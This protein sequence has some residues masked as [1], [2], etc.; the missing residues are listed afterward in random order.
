MS[1]DVQP[2][3]LRPQNFKKVAKHKKEKKNSSQ[4]EKICISLLLPS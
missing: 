1:K 3:F 2:A 4:K